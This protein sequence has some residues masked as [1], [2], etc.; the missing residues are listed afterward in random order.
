L[1]YTVGVLGWQTNVKALILFEQSG[2]VRDAFIAAGW[3]AESV[4]ILPHESG[5]N[6][7]HHIYDVFAFLEEA[8]ARGERWDIVIAHP[9]CTALSSSGNRW[10]AK[11]KEKYHKRI[12]AILES[13]L[14]AYELIPSVTQH[15][16]IENPVGSMRRAIGPATCT[17]QP[18]EHGHGET[19]RTCFWTM[20]TLPPLVPTDIVDGR[21]QRVWLMPDSRGRAKRRSRTYEGIARAMVTQW[22]RYVLG[23]GDVNGVEIPEP[24]ELRASLPQLPS[25]PVGIENPR[26]VV[27]CPDEDTVIHNPY[28]R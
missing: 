22:G 12:A 7:G 9:P 16:A 3:H 1:T 20:G 11:G 21:H 15:Y 18:W 26:H 28:L 25:E 5:D 13:Q 10:Y 23:Q 14:L 4:D 24:N 6:T 2:V 27:P 17:V 8:I 19:K